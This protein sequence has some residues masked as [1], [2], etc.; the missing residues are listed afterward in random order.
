MG[1]GNNQI[2][3]TEWYTAIINS[4]DERREL[5]TPKFLKGLES[6][7]ES[8]EHN[9]FYDK[10]EKKFII[11]Y[12]GKDYDVVLN[13]NDQQCLLNEEY[14]PLILKLLWLASKEKQYNDEAALQRVRQQKINTYVKSN[15]EALETIEDYEL[16]LDYLKVSLKKAKTMEEKNTINTKI[17]TIVQILKEMRKKQDNQIYNPLN[18]ELHINRFIYN[19]IKKLNNLSDKD[20][21]EI[22]IE[23]K[24]ILLDYKK[25]VDDYHQKKDNGLII[26]N[27][28][29]PTEILE[30]IVDVEFK[31]E[32]LLK[33]NKITSLVDLELSDV[34]S[35][36]N[37]LVNSRSKK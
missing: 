35:E 4:Y 8:T 24:R 31:V 18:L 11:T 7:L 3:F 13:S 21:Q 12:A 26:G 15:Y 23:L 22:A 27:P 17:A 37:S 36:L 30:R 34:V 32:S 14:S 20:R 33:S 25:I 1:L 29:M 2:V 10:D 16:Y 28:L 9:V 6:K 5:P 19:I